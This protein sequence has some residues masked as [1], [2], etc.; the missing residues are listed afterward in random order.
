MATKKNKALIAE[1]ERLKAQVDLLMIQNK[2][3]T[4]QIGVL[5]SKLPNKE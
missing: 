4:S 1:I 5:L 3:Q 2:E